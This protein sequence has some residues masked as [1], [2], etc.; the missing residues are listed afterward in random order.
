M[1]P[2]G[3]GGLGGTGGVDGGC[4]AAGP[5]PQVAVVAYCLM[6]LSSECTKEYAPGYL[7]SPHGGLPVPQETI[8]T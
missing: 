7:L 2:G 3:G 6:K 5:P 8:P 4:G 1:H